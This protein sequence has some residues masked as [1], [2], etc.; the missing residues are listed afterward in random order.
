MIMG[1]HKM[2]E[3]K[4]KSKSSLKEKLTTIGSYLGL[5]A[6]IGIG[7][8]SLYKAFKRET[9]EN[10]TVTKVGEY[11]LFY[12]TDTTTIDEFQKTITVGGYDKCLRPAEKF[13]TDENI[14]SKGMKVKSITYRNGLVGPC[15]YITDVVLE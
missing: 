1:A 15:D 5:C 3:D 11:H 12:Q 13:F 9:I 6:V 2:L 14:P 8:F 4:I 10:T 7:G